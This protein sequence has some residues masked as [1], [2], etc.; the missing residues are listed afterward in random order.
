MQ[1]KC[2]NKHIELQFILQKIAVH[3]FCSIVFRFL[4]SQRLNDFQSGHW[5][6]CISQ[7]SAQIRNQLVI[8]CSGQFSVD[9]SAFILSSGSKLAWDPQ[10]P[11]EIWIN[12]DKIVETKAFNKKIRIMSIVHDPL[13]NIDAIGYLIRLTNLRDREKQMQLFWQLQNKCTS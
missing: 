1:S 10:R 8:N 12:N 5:F 6:S 9:N 13:S 3:S 7:K 11:F 2:H 4:I